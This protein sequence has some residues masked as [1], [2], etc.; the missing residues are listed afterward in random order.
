MWQGANANNWHLMQKIAIKFSAL[1][2]E[3]EK[4]PT[5][6]Q[7]CNFDPHVHNLTIDEKL[8]HNVD[9]LI[10]ICKSMYTYR[11]MADL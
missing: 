8:I 5:L 6:L 4:P 9:L 11:Q 10:Y 3:I 2:I 1:L 7:F